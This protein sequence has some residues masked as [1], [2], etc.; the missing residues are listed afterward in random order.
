MNKFQIVDSLFDRGREPDVPIGRIDIL[1]PAERDTILRGWNDTAHAIPPATVPELFAAQ[2][3]RTPEAV[4]VVFEDQALNYGEL[5]RRAN[6][7]AHRLRRLG[8]GPD[9]P[10]GISLER[11]LE[12]VVGLLAIMKAGGA[13]VPLDPEYPVERLQ[14]M[15]ADVGLRVLLTHSSLSAIGPR[16][17]RPATR[18]DCEYRRQIPG[19]PTP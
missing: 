13:Y 9:V 11:S 12:L 7:L 17:E 14:Y 10:V 18:Q 6:Q 3:A 4:A 16:H 15:V 1:S 5:D 2:V 19:R 8:V